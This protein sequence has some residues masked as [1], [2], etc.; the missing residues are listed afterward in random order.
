[1]HVSFLENVETVADCVSAGAALRTAVAPVE[2]APM[3]S[4]YQYH[5]IDTRSSSTTRIETISLFTNNTRITIIATETT[6][7]RG[8]AV[9]SHTTTTTTMRVRKVSGSWDM[10][11]ASH[12]YDTDFGAPVQEVVEEDSAG[13]DF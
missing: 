1:M 10:K 5:T 11:M 9:L 12:E 3:T 13:E 4:V 2:C 8:I 6:Y 7:S